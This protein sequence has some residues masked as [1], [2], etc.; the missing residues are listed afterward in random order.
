MKFVQLLVISLA[1]SQVFTRF[2]R[3]HTRQDISDVYG[4][5]SNMEPCTNWKIKFE[6]LISDWQMCDCKSWQ[7]DCT[8]ANA[9]HDRKTKLGDCKRKI[10]N[11]KDGIIEF[12]GCLHEEGLLKGCGKKAGCASKGL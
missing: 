3:H 4:K 8:F 10:K 6:K 1:I 2:T 7:I 5:V 11:K 12:A 9:T